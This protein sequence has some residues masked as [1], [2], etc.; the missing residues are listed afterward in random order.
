MKCLNLAFEFGLSKYSHKTMKS[1]L[2]FTAVH[3]Q[4]VV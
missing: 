4:F 3:V 2:L 1:I